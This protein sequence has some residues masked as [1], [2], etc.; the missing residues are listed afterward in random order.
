MASADALAAA[1]AYAKWARRPAGEIA[2]DLDG[3][4]ALLRKWQVAQNLVSRETLHDIWSRHVMDSLQLLRHIGAN[5]ARF[6]DLGSGGGL[7]AIP[8][9]I[10]LGVSVRFTLIESNARKVSFL[11]TVARELHLPV[12]VESARIEQIDSRETFDV[13]T[14]RALAPL[15]E[16]LGLMSRFFQPKTRALLHKGREYGDEL[17]ESRA[18]FDFDM[19]VTTSD[20]GGGGVILEIT[21]LRAKTVA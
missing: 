17:A 4:V 16:L 8:L 18:Q 5:D 19:L 7:P 6:L 11:R 3:F 15:P 20:T 14:S 10:A 1:D 9:A 13:I 2:S 12:A 21:D